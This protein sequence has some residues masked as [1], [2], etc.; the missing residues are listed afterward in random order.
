M[1]NLTKNGHWEIVIM[2]ILDLILSSLITFSWL[3]LI[4]RKSSFFISLRPSFQINKLLFNVES[5][6]IGSEQQSF[7][8]KSN[9]SFEQL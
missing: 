7:Y 3:F 4:N 6:Y 2:N 1:I 9:L 5:V 8:L